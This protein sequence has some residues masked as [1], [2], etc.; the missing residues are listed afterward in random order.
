MER[1][2]ILNRLLDKYE[3]SKH[4][5]APNTSK[6]RVMLRVDKGELPEYAYEAAQLRDRFNAAAA[7]L[8]GEGII[9]VAFLKDRPIIAS[10]TLNLME[11]EKAYQ[12]AGKRHPAQVALEYNELITDALNEVK[13]EWIVNL[14][15]AVCAALT[16]TMRLPSFCRHGEAYARDFLRLLV[17]YDSLGDASIT[18]RALSS[19][20]FQNSKRFEL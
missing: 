2:L 5:S 10:L 19:V 1:G 18:L 9:E 6:R 4:L 12:A 20:C 15:D 8:H 17:E 3:K 13:A 16:Q 7:L 14:R 11:I